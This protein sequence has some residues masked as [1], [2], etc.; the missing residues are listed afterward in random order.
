MQGG[1][2]IFTSFLHVYKNPQTPGASQF[3]F[4]SFRN[5]NISKLLKGVSPEMFFSVL[6]RFDLFTAVKRVVGKETKVLCH[7]L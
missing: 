5:Q 7:F 3:K 4:A 6:K 2:S 1:G